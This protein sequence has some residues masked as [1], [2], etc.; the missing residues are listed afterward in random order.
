MRGDFSRADRVARTV[1]RVLGDVLERRV[2][3]PR[4]QAVTLTRVEMS[5]DLRHARV[6]WHLIDGED[7]SRRTDAAR[8]FAAAGGLLRSHLGRHLR[9]K[10]TPELDFRYDD[11][12]DETR[13]IEA[14]LARVAP[15]EPV[16]PDER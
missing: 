14:L 11:A 16:E 8:G 3:D 15:R 10:R 2:S 9:M 12:L 5:A 6:F 4:L 13:R 7:A 1:L